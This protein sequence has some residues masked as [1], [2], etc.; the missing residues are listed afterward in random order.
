MNISTP[1]S[2]LGSDTTVKIRPIKGRP[3]YVLPSDL[4]PF[5]IR[6]DR[7]RSRHFMV[8]TKVGLCEVLRTEWERLREE[9]SL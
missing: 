4:G 3:R 1:I 2:L 9:V 5:W 8:E 6:Y 7:D